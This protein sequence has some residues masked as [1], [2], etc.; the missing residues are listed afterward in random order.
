MWDCKWKISFFLS[1]ALIFD[2]Y[3]FLVFRMS[4]LAIEMVTRLGSGTSIS[5]K[6]L[7]DR[8]ESVAVP[9]VRHRDASIAI[10][11]RGNNGLCR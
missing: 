5:L 10:P 2:S 1:F 11:R 8:A 7:T 9:R 4:A 3:L 6:V